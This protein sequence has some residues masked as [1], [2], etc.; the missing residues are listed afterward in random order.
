MVSTERHAMKIDLHVHTRERSA[1][2]KSS[3][4]EQICIAIDVG[5]DAITLT[6]HDRLAPPGRL[7]ELNNKYVPFK[8]F[9]GIELSISDA[10]T[11]AFEHLLV[12]GVHDERLENRRWSYPELHRFV[13][14]H[15]G[16]MALAHPFR[17]NPDI[18]LDL[19][20]FPPD[21]IEAYSNNIPKH[22]EG[23]L[24]KLARHLGVPVLSNSD[25]HHTGVLGQYYNLLARTPAD[26]QE[27]IKLLKSEQYKCVSP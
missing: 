13:R 5:L 12:V 16:F 18:Q 17:F 11:L 27:L 26:E 20:R 23:R 21:A 9:G 19:E 6:D 25:A 7:Q 14:E 15:G 2:G 24:L 10:R 8:V 3:E 4:E 1:C 22:A